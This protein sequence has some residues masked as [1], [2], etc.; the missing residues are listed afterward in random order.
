MFCFAFTFP[1]E[2]PFRPPIVRLL[3]RIF[4]ADI[5]DGEN[6]RDPFCM[7]FTQKDWSPAVTLRHMLS[8]YEMRLGESPCDRTP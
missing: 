4:H 6:G 8:S 2:Y 1:P 5:L 3:T 7:N